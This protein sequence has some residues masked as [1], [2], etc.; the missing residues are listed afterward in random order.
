MW[1]VKDS[2]GNSFIT[3]L[4]NLL[5]E[6]AFIEITTRS[7]VHKINFGDN[8]QVGATAL[9]IERVFPNQ[10]MSMV[11]LI[12]T[13]EIQSVKL[14]LYHVEEETQESEDENVVE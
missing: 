12:N 2:V 14:M 1:H 9:I 10:S 7:D 6:N 13:N 4:I 3:D 8:A 11:T 5:N